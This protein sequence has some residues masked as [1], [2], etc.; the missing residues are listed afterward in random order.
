MRDNHPV[1]T[2]LAGRLEERQLRMTGSNAEGA[3]LLTGTVS[4]GKLR[5]TLNWNVGESHQAK[6]LD[7]PLTATPVR[8][9]E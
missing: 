1:V 3:V 4:D 9:P 2:A 6:D 8:P 7:L 5:G